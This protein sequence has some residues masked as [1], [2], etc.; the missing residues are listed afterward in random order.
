MQLAGTHAAVRRVGHVD[1]PCFA[2]PRQRRSARQAN[3]AP[4]G[5]A[6]DVDDAGCRVGPGRGARLSTSPFPRTAL[7]TRRASHPGTGLSTRPVTNKRLRCRS[8][9]QYPGLLPSR[10]AGIHR[11][12]LPCRPGAAASL[13]PF[14]MYTPLACSDYY[15]HSATTRHHQPTTRL[16]TA[17]RRRGRRRVASHV[18]HHPVDEVG[19]QLYPGSLARG[20]PQPFPLASSPATT[21]RLRSRPPPRRACTADRPTSARFGAGTSLTERQRWFLAYTFSS[22]LPDPDRLA[23]PT[24]PGVV[25][26]AP[27]LACV[28]TLRLPSASPACCDRPAAGPFHPRPVVVAPRGAGS[29]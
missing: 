10:D 26:A 8:A 3:R 15:G 11:R 27:T 17:Q 9:P 24:R 5:Q 25:R 6:P 23:V 22:C 14:A 4:A 20:T 29:A 21:Y 28:S 12:L 7:R 19:A 1:G 16:P 18:H 13:C 2:D